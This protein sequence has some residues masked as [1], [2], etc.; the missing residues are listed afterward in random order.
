M[1]ETTIRYRLYLFV[2]LSSISI[3]S[4]S[5]Q[6]DGRISGYVYGVSGTPIVEALVSIDALNLTCLTDQSGRFCF[7]S[8]VPGGYALNVSVIGYENFTKNIMVRAGQECRVTCAC[9]ESRVTLESVIVTLAIS[10]F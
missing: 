10:M 4:H 5:R 1:K 6:L 3:I 9:E 8:I 7:S 2:A